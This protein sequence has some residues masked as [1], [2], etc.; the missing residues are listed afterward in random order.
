MG[1][2]PTAQAFWTWRDQS[3]TLEGLAAFSQASF[4]LTEGG[5]DPAQIEGLRVSPGFFGFLGAK[6]TMGRPLTPEEV[7]SGSHLVVVLSHEL[8]RGRFG[9]DPEI[10]GRHLVLDGKSHR[11]VGVL[12]PGFSFVE[13]PRAALFTPLVEASE[14]GLIGVEALARLR[15]G[16]SNEVAEAELTSLLPETAQVQQLGPPS[17]AWL[18]PLA[19]RLNSKTQRPMVWLQ[20]AVGLVLLITCVNVALLLLARGQTREHEMATRAA[21]GGGRNRLFRQLFV[22]SLVLAIM[23]GA[24]GLLVAWWGLDAVL[25]LTPP[26]LDHLQSLDLDRTSLLFNAGLALFTALLFGLLPA[27]QGSTP[28]LSSAFQG[29]SRSATRSP[30]STLMRKVLVGCQVGLSF[31]LLLG[32]LSLGRELGRLGE[33]DFGFAVKNVWTLKLDLPP[34]QDPATLMASREALFRDLE[35]AK[36]VSGAR[37]AVATGLPSEAGMFIGVLETE[38]RPAEAEATLQVGLLTFAGPDYFRVLEIPMLRGRGFLPT[39]RSAAEEAVVINDV[40]A[41]SLWPGENPLGSRFRLAGNDWYRVIGVTAGT[42]ESALYQAARPRVYRPSWV[43]ANLLGKLIVRPSGDPEPIL[44]A[45]T[46]RLRALEPG[47][48]VERVAA[49]DLHQRELSQHRFNALLTALF[50]VLAASLMAVG[51]YGT[52]TWSVLGQTREIGLRQVLGADPRILV[53]RE[54]GRSLLPVAVGVVAGAAASAG[55]WR[56]ADGFIAGFVS[57]SPSTYLTVI[58]A[59]MVIATAAAWGP[60]QRAARVAPMEALRDD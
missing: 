12:A 17:K 29:R 26:S 38:E 51:I 25:A 15:P 60:A 52:V 19:E 30:R 53:R 36:H 39:D 31:C 49:D 8:W 45:L 41:E 22:E 34:H 33:V 35:E 42:R 28:E 57:G 1:Q 18:W 54:L 20:A 32:A 43:G 40:L 58:M 7:D 50:A 55:L 6:M 10:L 44:A 27:V 13:N 14:L 3:E 11:V 47:V 4:H 37:V 5:E 9:A 59:I 21:L 56:L 2:P 48:V 23:A 46:A 16:I 24:G